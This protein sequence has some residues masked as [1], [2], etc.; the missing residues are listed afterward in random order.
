MGVS[1]RRGEFKFGSVFLCFGNDFG[2]CIIIRIGQQHGFGIETNG[3]QIVFENN[4]L[5]GQGVFMF[6]DAVIFIIDSTGCRHY[7]VKYIAISINNSVN[8]ETWFG[9]LYK[10]AFFLKLQIP[11]AYHRV[12][13]LPGNV[14]GKTITRIYNVQKREWVV[15]QSGFYLFLG[16]ALVRP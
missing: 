13:G 5:V 8:V 10:N 16:I 9:V 3:F 12:A 11:V 2:N 4:F 6:F 14:F 15:P 7:A 1:V